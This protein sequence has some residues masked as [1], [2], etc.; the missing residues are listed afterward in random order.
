MEGEKGILGGDEEAAR[1]IEVQE[2]AV[3]AGAEILAAAMEN[4]DVANG[5]GE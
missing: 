2:G 1:L 4:G 5:V 3:V